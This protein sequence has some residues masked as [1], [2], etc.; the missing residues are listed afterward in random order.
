MIFQ[1]S[2]LID[3][4]QSLLE[5]RSQLILQAA[6]FEGLILKCMEKQ[7]YARET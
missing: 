7:D 4:D 2:C 5:P 1:K 6:I 3:V